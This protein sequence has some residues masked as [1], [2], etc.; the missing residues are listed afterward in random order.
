MCFF[1]KNVAPNADWGVGVCFWGFA[2]D[3]TVL[4][5]RVMDLDTDEI[6]RYHARMAHWHLREIVRKFMQPGRKMPAG[7]F[8][9]SHFGH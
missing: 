5:R 1:K 7:V 4:V 2:Q 6:T 3:I 8:L 9:P